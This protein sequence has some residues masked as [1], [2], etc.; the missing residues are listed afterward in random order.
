MNI[1]MMSLWI[2]DCKNCLCCGI[3]FPSI[4]IFS[5]QNLLGMLVQAIVLL[6]KHFTSIYQCSGTMSVPTSDSTLGTC[7][8]LMLGNQSPSLIQSKA[9][10]SSKLIYPRNSKSALPL[11]Y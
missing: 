4:G 3:R 1:N 10:T 2:P 7:K 6:Q 5:S 9:D 11:T 8:K